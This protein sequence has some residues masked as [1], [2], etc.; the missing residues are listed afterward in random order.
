MLEIP[1]YE[2]DFR[3]PVRSISIASAGS[4]FEALGFA[5]GVG[6]GREAVGTGGVGIG[7]VVDLAEVARALDEALALQRADV[8]AQVVVED[9]I[10]PPI[11]RRQTGLLRPAPL[12]YAVFRFPGRSVYSS[13]K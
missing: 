2:S 13:G 8:A 7:E 5:A 4:R 12:S 6:Y 3:L 9:G 11:K 10:P 1:L